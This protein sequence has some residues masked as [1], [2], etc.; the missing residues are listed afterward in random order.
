MSLPLYILIFMASVCIIIVISWIVLNTIVVLGRKASEDFL[1]RTGIQ[2][3]WGLQES[4]DIVGF[5]M[6]VN[7]RPSDYF[8]EV[9]IHC[10]LARMERTRYGEFMRVFIWAK[11]D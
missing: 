5:G 8:I 10:A 4:K 3:E 1:D 6:N 7:Q 11:C 9:Y 2:I